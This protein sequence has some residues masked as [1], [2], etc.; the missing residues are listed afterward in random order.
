VSLINIWKTCKDIEIVG[1]TGTNGKTTV[2][3]GIYSM[4]LDLGYRVGLQG[5]RGVFANDKIV[6]NK[7]M[8]TPSILETLH[9][10][11]KLKDEESIN[12]FVMEVSSHAIEQKMKR[13]GN[14][15]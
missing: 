1:V 9:N 7:H 8:T 13:S 2:T 4:L 10:I 5:T 6:K 12:F 11:K 14:S 15:P 3:A